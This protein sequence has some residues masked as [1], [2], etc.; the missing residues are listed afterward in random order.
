MFLKSLSSSATMGPMFIFGILIIIS[1]AG[2]VE[3]GPF[4]AFFTLLRRSLAKMRNTA[5]GPGT[6]RRCE[7]IVAG[8]GVGAATAE[9]V[10]HHSQSGPDTHPEQRTGF[11]FTL[12]NN[13]GLGWPNV[14][15]VLRSP[16]SN[17]TDSNE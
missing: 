16:P 17:Q 11:W 10:R 8:A 13:L 5:C 14:Y 12:Y 9:G 6:G 3:C 15:T 7:Y 4:K 2:P 1:F